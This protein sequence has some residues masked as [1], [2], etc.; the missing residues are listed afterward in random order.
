MNELAEEGPA[1]ARARTA[2]LLGPELCLRVF[3]GDF[4]GTGTQLP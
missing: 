1:R 2:H 3:P 4:Q